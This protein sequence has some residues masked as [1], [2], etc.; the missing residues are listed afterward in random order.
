MGLSVGDAEQIST[1]KQREYTV[2]YGLCLIDVC[3]EPD[4]LDLVEI[5]T[6]INDLER[7]LNIKDPVVLVEF[8]N[9][10]VNRFTHSSSPT[11][12]DFISL[13]TLDFLLELTYLKSTDEFGDFRPVAGVLEDLEVS[14]T[15]EL[16]KTARMSSAEPAKFV[17]ELLRY[18]RE[19]TGLWY[20]KYDDTGKYD[21]KDDLYLL[22]KSCSK[23]IAKI[24]PG[25]AT[26][27]L[28]YRPTSL[29]EQAQ[30]LN[31]GFYD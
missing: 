14:N 18:C 9:F 6:V 22:V 15:L 19:C 21:Y 29:V 4:R 30:A 5:P 1:T 27:S 26:D 17:E 24:Y 13:H 20:A 16:I 12:E 2:E 23:L 11:V 8:R 7:E 10:F 3:E 28:F 25:Y 31:P